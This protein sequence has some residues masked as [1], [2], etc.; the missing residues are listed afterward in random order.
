MFNIFLICVGEVDVDMKDFFG[1]QV[2]LKEM[3]Y[4]V[5]VVKERI[6]Y[7]YFGDVDLRLVEELICQEQ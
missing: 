2:I 4:Q 7:V 1:F 5:V 6:C 3:E